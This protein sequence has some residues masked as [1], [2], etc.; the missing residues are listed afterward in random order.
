MSCVQWPIIL[1]TITLQNISLDNASGST[2]LN[3][4]KDGE[5]TYNVEAVRIRQVN[6]TFSD[7][8][9]KRKQATEKSIGTSELLT[10]DINKESRHE[11]FKRKTVQ[12]PLVKV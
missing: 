5:N 8:D 2:D 9:E 12:K 10:G 1:F 7:I 11:K 6:N 3:L 4:E